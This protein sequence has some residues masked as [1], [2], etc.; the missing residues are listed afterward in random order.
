[1]A[2]AERNSVMTTQNTN[3]WAAF[4]QLFAGISAG[5]VTTVCTHPLD[6][7]KTRMQGIPKQIKL[8]LVERDVT[9]KVGGIVRV[10]RQVYAE[11]GSLWAFYRGLSPN[12]IG[13]AA[14]WGFYFMWYDSL[15]QVNEGMAR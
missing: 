11:Q 14:S 3:R 9:T 15:M 5:V 6:L 1:M 12:M 2:T 13:N 7:I 8:R 4:Q 10:A